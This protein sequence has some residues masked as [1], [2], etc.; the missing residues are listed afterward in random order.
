MNEQE[1]KIHIQSF[2]QSGGI[3]AHTV[4]IGKPQRIVTQEILQEALRLIAD[5]KG[6]VIS[7]ICVFGDAEALI[8]A[9][10]LKTLLSESGHTISGVDQGAYSQPVTGMNYNSEKMEFVIG[11][12]N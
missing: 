1:K 3:T 7:I 6:Q 11:T 10:Q 2:N 8:F 4:N 12:N 9:N 5:K